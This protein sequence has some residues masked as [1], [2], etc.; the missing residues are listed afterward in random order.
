[1]RSNKEIM[2]DIAMKNID[3]KQMFDR[4]E[5]VNMEVLLDIR[6]LLMNLNNKSNELKLC[7]L[8]ER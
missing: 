5:K 7:I 3:G 4:R 8:Q 6:E 2:N 1:M